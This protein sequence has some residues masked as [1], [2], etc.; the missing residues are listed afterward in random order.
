MNSHLLNDEI[1][2]KII[3]T[4]K[5]FHENY[6]GIWDHGFSMLNDFFGKNIK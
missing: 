5:V 6:P 2:I 4:Q 3:L 1:K